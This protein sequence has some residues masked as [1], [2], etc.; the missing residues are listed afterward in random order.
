MVQV[1]RNY[2]T[3]S[4]LIIQKDKQKKRSAQVNQ[5]IHLRY[6][7]QFKATAVQRHKK[8]S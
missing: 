3:R 7:H 8:R 2:H 1:E 6:A 4:K 5:S